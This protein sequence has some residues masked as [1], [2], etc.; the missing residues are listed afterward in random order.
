M[1]WSRLPD[2]NRRP[3]D[4]ETIAAIAEWREL[5]EETTPG[6]LAQVEGLPS[7]PWPQRI[8]WMPTIPAKKIFRGMSHC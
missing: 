6:L 1:E 2:L 7:A 4:Y 8:L 5:V 3:A